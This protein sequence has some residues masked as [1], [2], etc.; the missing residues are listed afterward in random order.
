MKKTQKQIATFAILAGLLLGV[1]NGYIALWKDEDP[2]PFRVFP[3]RVDSLPVADQL[4][5]QKGIR[6]NSVEELL[7]LAEDYL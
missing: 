5:L 6:I 7:R 4:Q 2:Q 1:K 3:I